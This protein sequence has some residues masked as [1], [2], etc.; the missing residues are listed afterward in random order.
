MSAD[1]EMSEMQILRGDHD[2]EFLAEWSRIFGEVAAL[3]LPAGKRADVAIY[4]LWQAARATPSPAPIPE[5]RAEPFA[6]IIVRDSTGEHDGGEPMTDKAE[7][8]DYM[9]NRCLPG[10]H[11]EALYRITPTA[12]ASQ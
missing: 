1:I 8:E 7:A 12:K 3:G 11:L 2:S 5:G 6:W 9:E 10:W 4:R